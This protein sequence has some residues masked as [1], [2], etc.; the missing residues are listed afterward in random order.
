MV[1]CGCCLGKLRDPC[2]QS[3]PTFLSGKC[4]GAELVQKWVD[5]HLAVGSVWI[6]CLF[7]LSDCTTF[8]YS[9]LIRD[10]VQDSHLQDVDEEGRKG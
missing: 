4:Y 7:S 1:K 6:D 2:L 5:S 10:D 8:R 3:I 9:L